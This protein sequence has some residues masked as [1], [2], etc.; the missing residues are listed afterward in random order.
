MSPTACS[1]SCP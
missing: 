1:C